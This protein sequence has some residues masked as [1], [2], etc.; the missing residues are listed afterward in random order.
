MV[1]S[2]STMELVTAGFTATIGAVVCIGARESG[3]GWGAAGPQGG[4]FPFYIGVLIMVG[5][6]GTAVKAVVAGSDGRAFLNAARARSVVSFLIPLIVLCALAA[7][8]GLY[9]AMA[10]YLIYAIWRQGGVRPVYA[11]AGSLVFTFANFVLFERL[12]QVP[13]LKGPLLNWFGIF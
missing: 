12:F 2:R 13:L 3:I 5:S 9:V 7:P 1:L 6:A 4:V 11:V 10:L 8:L